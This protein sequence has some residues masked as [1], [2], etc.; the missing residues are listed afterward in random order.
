M[1]RSFGFS[2]DVEV[3]AALRLAHQ[4]L[5]RSAPSGRTAAA[6]LRVA[7]NGSW[8]DNLDDT[9]VWDSPL[10][11]T[12]IAG[13]PGR[14]PMAL[15]P[16]NSAQTVSAAGYA[17][18]AHRTQVTG[19]VSFGSR[20]NDEPLQP[21]T[22]NTALPQL[23]LPRATAEAEAQ[24]LLHATS[25][26]CRA[27]ATDWRF[28]ARLRTLR[29]QQPD[30]PAT[31]IPQFINY[32]TSVA[33][34]STGGPELVRAQPHHLRRRRD[35]DRPAAAGA[36]GRLHPQPQ[37]LRPPHLREHE[38][39]RLHAQG[40]RRRHPVDH[41]PRA[42]RVRQPHRLGPRRRRARR[43]RRA[44]RRC[45]T[46]TSPTARAT[47]SPARSTSC[48]RELLDVQRHRRRRQRRLSTTATS[49]CRNRRSATFSLGADYQTPDG[50]GVG[51]SYNYERY[52]GLQQSR[53]ASPGAGKST[54]RPRDWTADST[55]TVH[56]F[57]IYVTPPR[58]GTNTEARARPTTSRYAEGNYVYTRRAR[59]PLPPPSQ[60]P[61][62]FNKL[63]QLHVDV[64]HRLSRQPGATFS[65]LYEPFRVYDFAF[66]PTVVNSIVQPSSLVLGYIY[67]PYTAQ[68][69]D[70]QLAVL[71]VTRSMA[72][73]HGG[74]MT[75]V[76]HVG[77][78]SRL[79]RRLLTPRSGMPPGRGR[80]GE[81]S[82]PRR[83]AR[84][85]TPSPARATRRTRSTASARSSRQPTSRKWFTNTGGDGSQAAEEA[86][87][88]MATFMKSKKLADADLDALVGVHAEPQVARGP[89]AAAMAERTPRP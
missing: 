1:G 29:L 55:E 25:A 58:F 80:E 14:G 39:E 65:Y 75:F 11:L 27:R 48:R 21:F 18:F 68:L 46:T 4:R 51:G 86:D 9:L 20:S 84:R 22:I 76:G 83:S 66:D 24:H 57:S 33:T 47:G 70:D 41:L 88:A 28:S 71:L 10:R 53:S 60:L 37:R 38:R 87:D 73:A 63:Q 35:V 85:A 64:R 81:G 61:E 15:W 6:M 50:L 40:R 45:A 67:R 12:D 19:F 89:G 2:N 69:S 72:D 5:R 23:T 26:W 32:D 54:I 31:A 36:H 34:R 52:T 3:R 62:V 8:F 17:K 13:G 78:C 82:T 49:G 7:Y 43:D 42:L 74:S 59:R 16:S 44:A 79:R 56:Y 30:T 77:G